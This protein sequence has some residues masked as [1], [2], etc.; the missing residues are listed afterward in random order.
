MPFAMP[1]KYF[2]RLNGVHKDL[3]SVVI[4][5]MRIAPT[6][7]A[8]V[9]TEGVRTLERQKELLSAGKSKTL[10]SRH[11]PE[12]NKC[13]QSCAVDLAVWSDKNLDR[14]VDSDEILWKFEEYKKLADVMKEAANN[15]NVKIEWGGDWKTLRDGPHFQ[16]PWEFYP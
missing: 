11:I 16:L 8:F 6:G 9:V 2:Q 12:S 15:M 10:R 5:A 1:I 7:F 14:V 3:S 4:E 13:R